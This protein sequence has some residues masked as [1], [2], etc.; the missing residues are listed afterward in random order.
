VPKNRI[1]VRIRIYICSIIRI[2]AIST[3]AV[4]V[5]VHAPPDETETLLKVISRG[6]NDI[7]NESDGD[8]WHP[9]TGDFPSLFFWFTDRE[10]TPMHTHLRALPVVDT[11]IHSFRTL[12]PKP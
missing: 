7:G 5:A 12:D 10:D 3:R 11:K 4:T 8:R 9:I 2:Q 1:R 6:N